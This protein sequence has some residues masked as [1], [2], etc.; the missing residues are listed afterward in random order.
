MEFPPGA[1]RGRRRPGHYSRAVSRRTGF[2]P[3][4]LALAPCQ[5]MANRCDSRVSAA[6]G[7]AFIEPLGRGPFRHVRRR[8]GLAIEPTGVVSAPERSSRASRE[9]ISASLAASVAVVW[10]SACC[11]ASKLASRAV[12]CARE[13]SAVRAVSTPWRS[14]SICARKPRTSSSMRAISGVGSVW[15][16]TCAVGGLTWRQHRRLKAGAGLQARFHAGFAAQDHARHAPGGDRQRQRDAKLQPHAAG[17]EHAAAEKAAGAS[18]D[19][20]AFALE[21]AKLLGALAPEGAVKA[22]LG[23][24]EAGKRRIVIGHGRLHAEIAGTGLRPGEPVNFDTLGLR[25]G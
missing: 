16:A 24:A 12:S 11:C 6:P 14:C 8:A 22:V 25:R 1:P 9:S 10:S 4:G 15:A 19:L 13:R 2:G 3:T 21:A 17:A 5:H 18:P 23:A 7:E 20:D